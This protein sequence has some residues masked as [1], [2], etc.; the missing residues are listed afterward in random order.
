MEK[1]LEIIGTKANLK[2]EKKMD[3]RYKKF[4]AVLFI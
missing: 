4:V 1:P 3:K 2:V